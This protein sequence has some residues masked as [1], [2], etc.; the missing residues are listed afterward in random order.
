[1]LKIIKGKAWFECGLVSKSIIITNQIKMVTKK[2]I[3]VQIKR[4]TVH[5]NYKRG[6]K[7]PILIK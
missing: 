5:K 2:I 6:K 4:W 7:C 1:M 3:M